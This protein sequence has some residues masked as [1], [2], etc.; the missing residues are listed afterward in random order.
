MFRRGKARIF[1]D[2]DARTDDRMTVEAGAK[3]LAE[4]RPGFQ[5]GQPDVRRDE[6]LAVVPDEGQQ[7]GLLFVLERHCPMPHEEDR[8]DVVEIGA[9]A[10]RFS[11]GLLRRLRDDV[12]I[13]AD[14]GI[15]GPGFI[16]EPLDDCKGV[17]DGIVLRLA[18]A[19]IG[20]GENRLA[21]TRGPPA[22][23]AAALAAPLDRRLS[24]GDSG[25]RLSWRRGL[26]R[27]HQQSRREQ[28]GGDERRSQCV[29]V[30]LSSLASAL[31]CPRGTIAFGKVERKL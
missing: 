30:C 15:V 7:L 20:P 18:V 16:A 11:G 4:L 31:L 28:S 17:R 23:T 24:G 2:H 14:V 27:R 5:C 29:H 21:H 26:L 12:G 3:Q 8:V 9:A 1:V 22:R 13:G 19:C 6:A 25:R 10:R